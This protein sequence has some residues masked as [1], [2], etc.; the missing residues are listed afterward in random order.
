V[1]SSCGWGASSA[2]IRET[3][4]VS[5]TGPRRYVGFDRVMRAK[6]TSV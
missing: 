5:M 3:I 6:V 1:K 2:D 4:T